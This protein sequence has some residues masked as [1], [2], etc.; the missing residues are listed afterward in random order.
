MN[1]EN[2]E[3]YFPCD[4]NMAPIISLLNKKGYIT[5]NCCEGHAGLSTDIDDGDI[6]FCVSVPYI[7]FNEDIE[8]NTNNFPYNDW[9]FETN[10]IMHDTYKAKRLS[11]S[12]NIDKISDIY[13]NTRPVGTFGRIMLY[14]KLFLDAEIKLYDWVFGLND[15]KGE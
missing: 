13:Q 14:R 15:I 1:K 12:Y 2:D 7:Q 5:T 6:L 10:I 8:I 11:I 9:E 4:D 3:L